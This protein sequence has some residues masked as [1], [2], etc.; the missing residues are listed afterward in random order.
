MREEFTSLRTV[1]GTLESKKEPEYNR[2]LLGT[3]YILRTLD[4]E[5]TAAR[6]RHWYGREGN[7]FQVD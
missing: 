4:N 2:I 3:I 6:Y 5:A 7:K 1:A